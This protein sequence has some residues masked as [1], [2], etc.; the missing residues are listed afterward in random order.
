MLNENTNRFAQLSAALWAL[1]QIAA[2]AT[3][4]VSKD[5]HAACLYSK[6]SDAVAAAQ[7]GDVIQV[8]HGSYPEDVVIG[9]AISLIGASRDN[10][11]IDATGMANG[12]SVTGVSGVLVS[13]FTVQN[14][15]F[16]GILLNQASQ[17]TI[18]DNHVLRNNVSLNVNDATC[19]AAPP[20]MRGR[21]ARRP[22]ARR[23]PA[24]AHSPSGPRSA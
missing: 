20:A 1:S 11:I 13:G 5:P 16:E 17:V 3:L 24:S 4:C 9:K 2:G 10:T 22:P 15:N 23:W 8:S 12:I 21:L 18:T 7:N 6:I 14:A 19:N